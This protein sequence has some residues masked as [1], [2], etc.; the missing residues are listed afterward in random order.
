[1]K[2]NRQL[3][4]ASQ[5]VVLDARTMVEVARVRLRHHLPYALHG[6]WVPEYLGPRPE[7]DETPQQEAPLEPSKSGRGVA[8]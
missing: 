4:G 3:L 8:A 6:Q 1:M 2:A 5:W 7:E